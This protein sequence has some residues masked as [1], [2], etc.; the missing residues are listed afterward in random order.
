MSTP[1]QQ[2]KR[3]QT[4]TLPAQQTK[5]LRLAAE[6]AEEETRDTRLQQVDYSSK[7]ANLEPLSGQTT[8]CRS[9]PES[10]D[11]SAGDNQEKQEP[12]H[13][14]GEVEKDLT[15]RSYKLCGDDAC[16]Y[17]QA[18][19]AHRNGFITLE[20]PPYDSKPA[21]VTNH[22]CN[23]GFF[24][25]TKIVAICNT[26][27]HWLCVYLD[28]QTHRGVVYDSLN[29]HLTISN[30]SHIHRFI[31]QLPEFCNDP[32]RWQLDSGQCIQ[33]KSGTDCGF[34]A[35]VFATYLILEI[36]IPTD[37]ESGLLIA[38][39]RNIIH[40]FQE[41]QC[42]NRDSAA[43]LSLIPTSIE[44]PDA[45]G[46]LSPPQYDMPTSIFD[47]SFKIRINYLSQ[48]SDQAVRDWTARGRKIADFT[49]QLKAVRDIFDKLHQKRQEAISHLNEQIRIHE[50]EIACL[51]GTV[52]QEKERERHIEIEECT[53]FQN[54]LSDLA[55]WRKHKAALQRTRGYVEYMSTF[56]KC[57]LWE[58][59]RAKVERLQAEC[60][61]EIQANEM[62]KE[63]LAHCLAILR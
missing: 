21:P 40:H 4:P 58:D 49:R 52:S 45:F 48:L 5:K 46:Q 53:W 3:P 42:G 11:V 22:N 17:M 12:D 15:Q 41:S 34:Y 28:V 6:E 47:E 59:D 51:E 20:M 39:W 54:L 7:P 56:H 55:V 9:S 13:F 63:G 62:V 38:L 18:L 37:D 30:V 29:D 10:N 26:P 27:N 35:I 8:L 1:P 23:C 61:K 60:V 25:E 2:R 57:I 33:Q 50:H 44:K 32:E 36:P 16:I 19:V 14:E 31:Q 24:K 43:T